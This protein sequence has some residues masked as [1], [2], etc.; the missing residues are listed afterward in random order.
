M[1]QGS[2]ELQPLHRQ[3]HSNEDGLLKVRK[4]KVNKRKPTLYPPFLMLTLSMAR[5]V[6]IMSYRQAGN[7]LSH[8]SHREKKGESRSVIGNPPVRVRKKLLAA[9]TQSTG[10]RKADGHVLATLLHKLQGPGTCVLCFLC[11]QLRTGFICTPPSHPPSFLP[12]EYQEGQREAKQKL[13][14]PFNFHIEVHRYLHIQ[15]TP[16]PSPSPPRSH[17]HSVY[18]LGS[19]SSTGKEALNL[20]DTSI[21]TYILIHTSNPRRTT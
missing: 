13:S 9:C 20:P 3:D 5:D 14:G 12:F 11:M 18:L 16:S 4:I 2:L 17:L 19:R 21:H 10:D 8:T 15:H 7:W 6:D 1:M